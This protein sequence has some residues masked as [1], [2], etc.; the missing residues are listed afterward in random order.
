MV[1][2]AGACWAHAGISMETAEKFGK[3]E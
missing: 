2:S 1:M 3:K